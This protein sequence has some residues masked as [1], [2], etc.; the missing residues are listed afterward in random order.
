MT[1]Y[2]K[3]QL[4]WMIAHGYSLSDLMNELS[5]LQY[6]DPEDSDRISSTVTELFNIWECDCGFGSEIWACEGEWKDYE[7]KF[8]KGN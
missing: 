6:E 1:D 8:E 4:E 7:K 5:E 2:Q 3:Y